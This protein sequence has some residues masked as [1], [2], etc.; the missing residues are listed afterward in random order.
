MLTLTHRQY[1]IVQRESEDS[2]EIC[3]TQWI[4]AEN[5]EKA[6]KK[7]AK[8]FGFNY[9]E[10]KKQKLAHAIL[11]R[12]GNTKLIFRLVKKAKRYNKQYGD[13]WKQ[14]MPKQ[15]KQLEMFK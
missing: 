4:M 14:N 10:L 11:Y 15:E 1:L 9:E 5:A 7:Y 12:K 8:V 2:F 3:H 6:L 13:S